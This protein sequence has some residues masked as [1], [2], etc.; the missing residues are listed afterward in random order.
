MPSAR[1]IV[2]FLLFATCFATARWHATPLLPSRENAIDWTHDLA[3]AQKRSRQSGKPIILLNDNSAGRRAM[4]RCFAHPI[5]ADATADLFVPL[6]IPEEKPA[7]PVIRI[8][9]ADGHELVAGLGGEVSPAL[10]VSRLVVA[11]HAVHHDIPAYLQLVNG[12]YN[13]A[14]L[15]NATFAVGCYWEGEEQFGKLSGV[16]STRTGVLGNDEVVRVDFDANCIDANML[17][18]QARSL[19]YFA[20]VKTAATAKLQF[21]D[22]QQHAL[23]YYPEY[24]YLPLTTLQAIRVNAALADHSDPIACLSPSQRTMHDELRE[25]MSRLGND[26]LDNLQIDRSPDG[27]GK[28]A[29]SLRHAISQLW[30]GP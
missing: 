17:L 12:E 22:D 24:R 30:Q 25:I 11:L 21:A 9:D 27:L 19:P 18:N 5:I 13:P 3:I 7:Q 2:P 14:N 23:E 16:V 26:T 29:Q 28:Y 4:G 20:S 8:L 10:L 15:Q 6:A 1:A